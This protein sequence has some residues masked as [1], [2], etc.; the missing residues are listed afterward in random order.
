M[1]IIQ[2]CVL[3]LRQLCISTQNYILFLL[4]CLK[5]RLLN[6]SKDYKMANCAIIKPRYKIKKPTYY[7][8]IS[9][10]SASCKLNIFNRS[11][12]HLIYN[13]LST[14]TH[15]LSSCLL[16]KKTSMVSTLKTLTLTRT[17][18]GKTS[19]TAES[20]EKNNQ[21]IYTLQ[22]LRNHNYTQEVI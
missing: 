15:K 6:C 1:L 18:C 22:R 17:S 3:L 16:I 11:C 2:F 21:L 13:A 14:E 20:S 4:V 7:I 8:K 12:K 5:S 19:E 9:I 10:L